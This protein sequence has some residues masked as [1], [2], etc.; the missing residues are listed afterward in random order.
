M[1]NKLVTTVLIFLIIGTFVSVQAENYDTNT[2]QSLLIRTSNLSKKIVEFRGLDIGPLLLEDDYNLPT[3][4]EVE[5][6]EHELSEMYEFTYS[7]G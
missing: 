7:E 1:K 2:G 3:S 6:G 5:T 4:L